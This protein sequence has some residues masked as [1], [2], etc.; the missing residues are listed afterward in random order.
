MPFTLLGGEMH[1]ESKV[2]CPRTKH[3]Y[4]IKLNKIIVN[5]LVNNTSHVLLDFGSTYYMYCTCTNVC[6]HN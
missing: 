5:C 1:C 6:V 2:F 4:I 3:N